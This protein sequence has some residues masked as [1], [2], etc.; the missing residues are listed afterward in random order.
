MVHRDSFFVDDETSAKVAALSPGKVPERRVAARDNRLLPDEV[1][2]RLQLE[3]RVP[4][5]QALDGGGRI[6]AQLRPDRRNYRNRP[7]KGHL[8]KTE[9]RR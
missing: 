6:R 5:L 9:N 8:H 2:G 7:S 3:Q 1:L 4:A